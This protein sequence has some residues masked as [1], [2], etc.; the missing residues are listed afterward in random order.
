MNENHNVRVAWIIPSLERGNYWQP[1]F[2]EFTDKFNQTIIYTGVWE[3]FLPGFEGTFQ[4][5][6]IGNAQFVATRQ[7]MGYSYGFSYLSP[8][9]ILALLKFQ[10]H[11]IFV[12]G[13]SLWTLLVLLFKPWGKWRVIIVY[14]GSS[15]TIDYSNSKLRLLLRRTM[16]RFTDALITNSSGGKTYL[17]KILKAQ[18]DCVLARPYQVPDVKT[19]LGD[20]GQISAIN[21]GFEHPVFLFVG[22]VIH[23][24]GV[25]FL[26]EA[27]SI[28]QQQGYQKYTLLIIG[29]GEQRETLEAFT[30]NQGL[31]DRIRW[32]GWLSYDTLGTYFTGADVFVFPSLEDIWGMV[33]LEAMAFGKPILCSKWAGASELVVDGENGYIFEPQ[34][35][36]KLAELMR[37]FIDEPNLIFSMGRNSQQLISHHTPEAAANFLAEMT[38]FVLNNA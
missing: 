35:P 11:V 6:Q 22:K 26:L 36:E 2:K 14:D 17:T 19:I 24:K 3:R 33:V 31:S 32:L 7:G 27:C 29:D 4:V 38:D 25:K 20:Q 13:F 1:V 9:I 30:Q 23:Q 21:S 18:E 8:Q 10:P 34:E 12:S 37:R 28:L 15:P 16:V 5:Q